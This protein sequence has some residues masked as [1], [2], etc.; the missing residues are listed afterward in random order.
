MALPGQRLSQKTC[1][2]IRRSS[3]LSPWRP[4]SPWRLLH[5]FSCTNPWHRHSQC[6]S[7]RVAN[8]NNSC[9][10]YS[11]WLISLIFYS[12]TFSYF[13][14]PSFHEWS[15]P[16]PYP[17]WVHQPVK[18]PKHGRTRRLAS[19]NPTVP[20]ASRIWVRQDA[21]VHASANKRLEL[22]TG[23]VDRFTAVRILGPGNSM[24]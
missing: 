14:D 15:D 24:E 8:Q 5:C 6:C 11:F 17:C 7:L 9:H 12:H 3:I 4:W 21:L 20:Y 10:F 13:S 2:A 23:Q 1:S 18:R 16:W 22:S 19:C